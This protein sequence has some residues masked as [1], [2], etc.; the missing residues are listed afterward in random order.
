VQEATTRLDSARNDHN[1][2]QKSKTDKEEDLS[3]DYGEQDIFR[4]LK[5]KCVSLDAGEYTY[6][7]CHMNKITQ[8]SKKNGAHSNN[9]MGN[10]N[11][12]DKVTVN[13]EVRADGKGLGS[14][15]RVAMKYENGAH[16]W[17]GPNRSVMVVLACAEN[18]EVWK[19]TEEEKCVYRMEVGTPAVCENPAA[20]KSAG[21]GA[22]QERSEL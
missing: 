7:L 10:F 15:E 6:E 12:F 11:H 13:E 18:E 9:H 14:G 21:S 5:D 8:K 22:G 2:Q 17:N 20:V 4:P 19:V 16:C 3:K 1:N